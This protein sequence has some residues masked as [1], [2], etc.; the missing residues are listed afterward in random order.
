MDSQRDDS[1]PPALG[2]TAKSAGG[3]FAVAMICSIAGYAVGHKNAVPPFP[4]WRDFEL[5]AA[6][7][8]PAYINRAML[9]EQASAAFLASKARRKWQHL[10]SVIVP[11]LVLLVS[12]TMCGLGHRSLLSEWEVWLGTIVTAAPIYILGA[13]AAWRWPKNPQIYDFTFRSLFPAFATCMPPFVFGFV[14]SHNWPALLCFSSTV[15]LFWLLARQLSTKRFARVGIVVFTAAIALLVILAL[16]Y[17]APVAQWVQAA[18]FGILLTLAMGVSEAWRVTSRVLH[19]TEFRPAAYTADE[20]IYY[21]G[22]T[23]AATA[24]FL[25]CFLITAV[26]P[27]TTQTYLWSVF[28]LLIIGYLI[29]FLDRKPQK[30]PHW[31]TIG[32]LYGLTL[33]VVVSL[34]TRIDGALPPVGPPD[35]TLA[36]IGSVI[37]ISAFLSAPLLYFCRVLQKRLKPGAILLGCISAR[38]CV[39]ITGTSASLILLLIGGAWIVVKVMIGTSAAAE[40]RIVQVYVAYLIVIA[41]CILYSAISWATR[42]FSAKRAM[43]QDPPGPVAPSPRILIPT[44]WYAFQSTRPLPSVAAGVLTFFTCGGIGVF[45]AA[46]VSA[47]AVTAVTMFGFVV[48]D[49][50]DQEKDRRA[51][52]PRPLA[53]NLISRSMAVATAVFAAALAHLFAACLSTA[54][55][56]ATV[57]LCVALVCYT[58]FARLAPTMKGLYTAALACSPLWYAHLVSGREVS[59]HFYVILS[60]FVLGREL[61]MD[62]VERQDDFAAGM[63][64]L[65]FVLGPAATTRFGVALIACAALGLIF[66]ANST[67]AYAF[68]AATAVS[69]VWVAATNAAPARKIAIT[70]PIMLIGAF[71]LVAQ[72]Q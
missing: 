71:A 34:C 7:L 55:L 31:P 62:V 14:G 2:P 5:L 10:H 38:A 37:T 11:L 63:R 33:P 52:V 4:A 59:I 47:M 19:R 27:A 65:P 43:R 45:Y 61:L 25:P 69:L 24:L 57:C 16:W 50:F 46:A 13:A 26:H 60:A 53:L 9:Y 48:N 54:A 29:W 49:L 28:F 32:V 22:G 21:R 40:A 39:A 70:R 8:F 66:T 58:G 18:T 51:G 1:V 44:L 42:S 30:S 41:L 20:L 68:S 15:L 36:T 35:K 56:A 67:I 72:I 3:Y 64:T 23:N 6:F 17:D 12:I